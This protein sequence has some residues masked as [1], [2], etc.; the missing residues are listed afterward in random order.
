MYNLT[1]STECREQGPDLPEG[2]ERDEDFLLTFQL[3]E[4]LLRKLKSAVI[5]GS[6]V[7]KHV[8]GRLFISLLRKSFLF[9][10]PTPSLNI[11]I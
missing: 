10:S 1:Q 4:D 11:L 6:V 2:A 9:F 5:L 3:V 7:T 8:Q